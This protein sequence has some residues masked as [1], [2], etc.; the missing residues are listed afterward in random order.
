M[1]TWRT[2]QVAKRIHKTGRSPVATKGQDDAHTRTHNT[3]TI[4]MVR[5][6]FEY[7]AHVPFD[8]A[9]TPFT[10]YDVTA[11]GVNY[12]HLLCRH[13]CRGNLRCGDT[14]S[15]S[16]IVSPLIRAWGS[17][18]VTLQPERSRISNATSGGGN[19]G[20]QC[21]LSSLTL[22]NQHNTILQLTKAPPS[23]NMRG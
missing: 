20:G 16:L 18:V 9:S 10:L 2:H 17:T 7:D 5:M 4:M 13:S 3:H 22:T 15:W 12:G 8:H 6:H 14:S 19:I 1:A 23:V 11:D 21:N